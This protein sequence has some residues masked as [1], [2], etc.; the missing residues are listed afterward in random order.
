[1][2]GGWAA[3]F[4]LAF[5]F[6]GGIVHFYHLA[7]LG[8]PLAVLA[9]IGISELYARWKSSGERAVAW[10][11]LVCVTLLWQAYLVIGQAGVDA[12]SSVTRLGLA[13]A[14]IALL[15]DAVSAG[16]TALS[17]TTWP[18][19][20]AALVGALAALMV[21]PAAGALSVVL[22]RPNVSAPMATLAAYEQPP[23]AARRG[24][25]AANAAAITSSFH[26]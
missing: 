1:M 24:L 23:N 5:S 13:D 3:T 21:M 26:T 17:R 20:Q 15:L 14:A 6:A 19:I 10:P 2:S 8:P 9:G 22:V 11:A 16:Q 25:G 12:G 18:D 4:W 7:V